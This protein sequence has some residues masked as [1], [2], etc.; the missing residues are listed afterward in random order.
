MHNCKG[1]GLSRSESGTFYLYTVIILLS[2]CFFIPTA[3][4]FYKPAVRSS[5]PCAHNSS[6]SVGDRI[7]IIPPSINELPSSADLLPV[8]LA[9]QGSTSAVISGCSFPFHCRLFHYL[10]SVIY[11]FTRRFSVHFICTTMS[12]SLSFSSRSLWFSSSR[13]FL[14]CLSML[15]V[16]VPLTPRQQPPSPASTSFYLNI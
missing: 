4:L 7:Q 14:Q 5:L 10:L 9:A 16:F 15:I 12:I 2:S 1:A 8:I 11:S 13:A 6:G 3:V